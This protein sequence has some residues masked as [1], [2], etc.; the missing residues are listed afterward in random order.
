MNQYLVFL[1][2]FAAS[3][4]MPGPEIAALLSRS[5]ANGIRASFALAAGIVIGKLLML[6]AAVLG[7]AALLAL[8][9]PAFVLL[10]YAGAAYLVWLGVKKWRRAGMTLDIDSPP[11]SARLDIVL[12]VAM[13]VSN[14]M[15]LVFY[16]ALL[17]GVIDVAG[18]TPT[19]Y[20]A[21]CAI[22]AGVMALVTL[23]YGLLAAA[24]RRTLRS[25]K[26]KARADRASGAM[27][28]GVGAM[29]A[30]R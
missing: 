29:I 6:T 22:I 10:K 25:T 9:G 13:T 27:M 26:A 12:G 11:P 8:L 15:A 5:V 7:L 28:V 23:G 20:A 24:A 19:S 2:A 14:P 17:P 1:L 30:A 16:M 3:A 18:V 21:L 4:A